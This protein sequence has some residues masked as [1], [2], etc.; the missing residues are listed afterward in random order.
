[1][2][3]SARNACIDEYK[4]HKKLSFISDIEYSEEQHQC[5]VNQLAQNQNIDAD[6]TSLREAFDIALNSLPFY[7]KEAFCLQQEGFSIE[8]IAE[9]TQT[10]KETCKTR[11]RYARE[12]L[13]AQ[14]EA[15]H[16]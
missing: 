16:V 15:Y 7:Q 9:I 11:L 3:T 2:Y 6:S 1:M 5:E 10:N 13:Q 4:K 12:K 8:D 14:M